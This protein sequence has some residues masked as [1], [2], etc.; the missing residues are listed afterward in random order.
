M[1]DRNFSEL[2]EDILTLSNLCKKNAPINP[3]LYS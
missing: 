2:T 3:E 1:S